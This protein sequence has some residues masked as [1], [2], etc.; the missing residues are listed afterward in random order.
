MSSFLALTNDIL[1]RSGQQT[2][3]TLASAQSPVLQAMDFINDCY[4][5]IV[6][7]VTST[8]LETTGTLST[9]ASTA[10]YTLASDADVAFLRTAKIMDT[11]QKRRLSLINPDELTYGDLIAV[12][13]PQGF[14]CEGQ[15]LRVYP[16]PNGIYSLSYGYWKRPVKLVADADV[17]LIPA[18]WERLL[19]RGALAHF[20]RYMGDASGS[21][22]HWVMYQEGLS[23]LRTRCETSRRAFLKPYYPPHKG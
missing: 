1:R 12:G 9:V 3:S 6:Q 23:L 11:T 8:W 15:Q 20:Y 4:L 16:I 17:P 18:A 21:E 2:V 10:T 22:F 13:A 5:D 7:S 19:I 14:W